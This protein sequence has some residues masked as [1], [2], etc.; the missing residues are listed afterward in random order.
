[1]SEFE[2]STRLF[3]SNEQVGNYNHEQ[4]TK[5]EHLVAQ[6]NARHSSAI[7]EKS[8]SDDM[9]GLEPVDLLWTYCGLTCGFEPMTYERLTS[10]KSSANLQYRLQEENRL[11]HLAHIICNS[12]FNS[13]NRSG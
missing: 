13:L 2:D 4:L 10:L 1:M 12:A 5:L 6:I 11:Y 8:S 9:S 7:A 3:Y